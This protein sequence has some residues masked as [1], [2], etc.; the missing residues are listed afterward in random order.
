[1]SPFGPVRLGDLEEGRDTGMGC[2]C[3]GVG[4]PN[5]GDDGDVGFEM[6]RL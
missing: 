1:M 3:L 6:W 2:G 4:I 5:D